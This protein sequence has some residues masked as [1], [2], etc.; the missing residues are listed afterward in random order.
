MLC[1]N[2]AIGEKFMSFENDLFQH[3]RTMYQQC[4]ITESNSDL[5]EGKE[6]RIDIETGSVILVDKGSAMKLNHRPYNNKWHLYYFVFKEPI[7]AIDER[8]DYNPRKAMFKIVEREDTPN[9]KNSIADMEK[10]KRENIVKNGKFYS[11]IAEKYMSKLSKYVEF[12]SKN[13]KKQWNFEIENVI[14]LAGTQE[15]EFLTQTLECYE[16]AGK[17]ME[18]LENMNDY[19]W[20]DFIGDLYDL[21]DKMALTSWLITRFSPNATL[22]VEAAF[23]EYMLDS[24]PYI[25]KEYLEKK[26]L[27]EAKK[28]PKILKFPTKKSNE[29]NTPPNSP[30]NGE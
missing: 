9:A 8:L 5:P 29:Q 16:E 23:E 10:A 27:E 15:A 7:E 13:M 14:G 12:I 26:K 24:V 4:S 22:F 2:F 20:F 17:F 25:K 30:S 21:D 19:A 6:P 3:I 11:P 18:R 28:G 1:Y